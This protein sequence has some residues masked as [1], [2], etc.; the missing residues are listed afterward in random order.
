MKYEVVGK[1]RRG[2]GPGEGWV[3]AGAV[4]EQLRLVVASGTVRSCNSECHP[5]PTPRDSD[6]WDPA[7]PETVTSW[8]VIPEQRVCERSW[9]TTQQGSARAHSL[10]SRA[11]VASERRR[12][13]GTGAGFRR[14]TRES[15]NRFATHS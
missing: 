12:P 14:R 13:G 7:I 4:F 11:I 10:S 6:V 15:G 1:Q 9:F 8:T 2:V 5:R 3:G